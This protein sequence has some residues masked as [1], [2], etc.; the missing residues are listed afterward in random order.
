MTPEAALEMTGCDTKFFHH[1]LPIFLRCSMNSTAPFTHELPSQS[2]TPNTLSRSGEIPRLLRT[3]RNRFARLSRSVLPTILR[4]RS[5]PHLH[6]TT[7]VKPSLKA[8]RYELRIDPAG[9]SD[10][11][12]HY[13]RR[14]LKPFPAG[15]IQRIIA[16]TFADQVKKFYT[17]GRLI[18]ERI[19]MAERRYSV[20]AL[21]WSLAPVGQAETQLPQPTHLLMFVDRSLVTGSTSAAWKRQVLTQVPHPPADIGI[22][23]GDKSSCLMECLLS[24]RVERHGG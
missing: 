15:I 21:T 9:A 24:A 20:L 13:A 22:N 17:V 16:A 6:M 1:P 19:L 23:L 12:R 18:E 8:S 2:F 7:P 5:S 14:I 4:Q 10:R 11:K 3:T